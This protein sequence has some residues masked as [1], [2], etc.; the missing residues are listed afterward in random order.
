M[1]MERS[2][3]RIANEVVLEKNPF[4]SFV[5]IKSPTAVRI[6]ADVPNYVVANAGSGRGSERINAAHI[7]RRALT[8]FFDAVIL[9][10]IAEC[11]TTGIPPNPAD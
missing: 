7:R 1:L 8:D 10:P 2:V 6:R 11:V 4:R 3:R 5:G 9:D